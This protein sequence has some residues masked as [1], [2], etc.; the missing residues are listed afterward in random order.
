MEWFFELTQIFEG[1]LGIVH[2]NPVVKFVTY[3]FTAMMVGIAGFFVFTLL[4]LIG[5][6]I[7]NY[8]YNI[9]HK[10]YTVW[11]I[12][13]LIDP[14][15]MYPNHNLL[16]RN[17]FEGAILDL[18]FI[19]KGIEKNTLYQ[20]YKNAGLWDKNLSNLRNAFWHKRLESLVKMDLWQFSLGFERI[21]HLLDDEDQQI[22]QIALKNLSRTK[23]THEAVQVLK[24][25]ERG[26]FF[27]SVQYEVIYRLIRVHRELVLE[28]LRTSDKSNLRRIIV[29]V[30]GDSRIL[31]GVPSLLRISKESTDS[32]EKELALISLG[33]I[34][35]PRSLEALELGLKSNEANE[36]LASLHSIYLIDPSELNHKLK[37]LENDS[38]A[39]VRSWYSHYLKG[40]Q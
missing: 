38:N 28:K 34:G 27:Y 15:V 3:L 21:Q 7:G 30:I 2:F 5:H 12:N 9:F 24:Y 16:F 23:E 13:Y 26:G 35:D 17:A 8:Y 40:G 36:R 39:T 29:K 32:E 31:E 20:V 25:L 14:E 1:F 19:T 10:R 37:F 33:K 11:I 4:T 18:L 6:Q 22:R